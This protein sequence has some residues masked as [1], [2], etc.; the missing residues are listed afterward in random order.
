MK[1]WERRECGTCGCTVPHLLFTCIVDSFGYVQ[2]RSKCSAC[3]S[4]RVLD[5]VLE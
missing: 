5:K 4:E 1:T 2:D 3:G